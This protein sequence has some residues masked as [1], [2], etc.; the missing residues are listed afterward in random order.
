MTRIVTA[1]FTFDV[2]FHS[3]HQKLST[4]ADQ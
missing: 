4:D 2:R 1:E 3:L